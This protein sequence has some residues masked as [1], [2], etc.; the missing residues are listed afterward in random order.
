MDVEESVWCL[1]GDEDSKGQA[2]KT[3][4][5]SLV[6]PPLTETEI[7]WKKGGASVSSPCKMTRLVD[8]DIAKAFQASNVPDN[9]DV[10][11]S[12][13]KLKKCV[14]MHPYSHIIGCRSHCI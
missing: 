1:D 12:T 9:C 3:L 11:Q 5:I 14:I 8:I 2:C 13:L 6:R 7:T 10:I 4:M